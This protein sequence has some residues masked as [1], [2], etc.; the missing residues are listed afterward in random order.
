[1][2]GLR[3]TISDAWNPSKVPRRHSPKKKGIVVERMSRCDD[4]VLGDADGEKE[5]GRQ[6]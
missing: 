5:V 6:G 1:V 3:I 4:K 2:G